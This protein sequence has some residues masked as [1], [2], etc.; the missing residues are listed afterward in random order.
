MSLLRLCSFIF[1]PF[2]I[3]LYFS[4]LL[5]YF[6]F[7]IFPS[8][9][10]LCS[11][12]LLHQLFLSWWVKLSVLAA[13]ARY[14]CHFLTGLSFAGSFHYPFSSFYFIHIKHVLDR[15]LRHFFIKL[16]CMFPQ[17]SIFWFFLFGFSFLFVCFNIPPN[18]PFLSWPL[19]FYYFGVLF[20]Y[21]GIS[22]ILFFY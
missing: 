3:L 16:Y 15:V 1:L 7:L 6:L 12:A 17:P 10:G 18:W 5:L 19:H 9:T 11:I 13:I 21:L 20:L 8:L 22:Y 14:H 2:G 4:G